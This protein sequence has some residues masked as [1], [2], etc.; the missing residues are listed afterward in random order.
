[1][2]RTVR[3]AGQINTMPAVLPLDLT[4]RMMLFVGQNDKKNGYGLDVS[5]PRQEKSLDP[6]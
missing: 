3:S 1:M 2:P 6:Q 4:V 5:V